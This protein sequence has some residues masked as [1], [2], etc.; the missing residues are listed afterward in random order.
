MALFSRSVLCSSLALVAACAGS[1]FT[2]GSLPPETECVAVLPFEIRYDMGA[3]K[4]MLSEFLALDLH[5]KGMRGV[6]GPLELIELFKKANDPLPP[7]TDPYWA[8]EVGRK[9]NVDAVLFGTIAQIPVSRRPDN[10]IEDMNVNIDA[11][12]MDVKTGEIR[13][14]FGTKEQVESA[15]LTTLVSKRADEMT[16]VLLQDT[17]GRGVFGKRD[18]WSA[19]PLK[20]PVTAV[21]RTPEPATDVT[22]TKGQLQLLAKVTSP[23]GLI[24]PATH[25]ESRTGRLTK[26]SIQSLRDLGVV[27]LSGRNPG[28]ILIAGHLDATEDLGKDLALSK[29]RAEAVRMYLTK[30]GVAPQLLQ[31]VGYGGS[32]PVM[33]NMNEKSR[34]MN[35]RTEV[36][37]LGDEEE[38]P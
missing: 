32:R 27:M 12:L 8:R 1:R 26:E 36:S 20:P 24:L 33:P 18:C 38:T 6:L 35:R 7:A 21:V 5:R 17:G 10:E 28:K 11:Y 4:E 3:P 19:P 2:V 31:A 34:R 23:E 30:M 25:F 9:L 15:E 16:G 13:W 22:L 37:V 29:Q 14:S